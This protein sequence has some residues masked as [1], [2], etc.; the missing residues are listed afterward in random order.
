MSTQRV[1]GDSSLS[2]I[3]GTADNPV[4]DLLRD[5]I[6]HRLAGEGLA[7]AMQDSTSDDAATAKGLE[8][9]EAQEPKLA[10]LAEDFNADLI[11]RPTSRR[12]RREVG[13]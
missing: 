13:Q 3:R 10:Q 5:A 4:E 6:A 7:K 1:A 9:L 2:P 12:H 8:M 11:D